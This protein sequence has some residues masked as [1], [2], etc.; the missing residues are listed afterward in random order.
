MRLG[1]ECYVFTYHLGATKGELPNAASRDQSELFTVG[2]NEGR[3]ILEGSPKVVNG[4]ISTEIWIYSADIRCFAWS[5]AYAP[6]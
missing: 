1:F 3:R 2:N 6:Y 4:V 5:V